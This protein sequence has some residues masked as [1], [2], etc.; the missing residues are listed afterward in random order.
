MEQR[1]IKTWLI[2]VVFAAVVVVLGTWGF[3]ETTVGHGRLLNDVYLSL[4]LFPLHSGSEA[5]KPP[6]PLQI[7]RFSAPAVDLLAF[8]TALAL[9]IRGLYTRTRF[10]FVAG[11]TI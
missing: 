6:L 11:H 10:Q 9:L 8:L 4:Q 1:P 3:S 7:A 2:L 5:A